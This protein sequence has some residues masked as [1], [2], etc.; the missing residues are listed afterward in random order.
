MTPWLSVYGLPQVHDI[1]AG[2]QY[3]HQHQIIHN[4]LC[5]VKNK[6][7][8]FFTMNKYRY[9]LQ[10]HILIKDDGSACLAE[11]GASSTTDPEVLKRISNRT[12]GKLEWRA[13]ELLVALEGGPT[14]R[15]HLP[16]DVYSLSCTVLE[17]IHALS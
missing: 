5:G 12:A 17:V 3:L 7:T 1:S 15:P 10:D 13:P 16:S 9:V 11:F 2:L 14:H 8:F 6:R 4:N